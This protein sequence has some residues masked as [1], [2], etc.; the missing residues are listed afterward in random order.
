MIGIDNPDPLIC[1]EL[2]VVMLSRS[3]AS[4]DE[5]S[6][7]LILDLKPPRHAE[8]D[9]KDFAPI[10]M[11]KNILRPPGEPQDPAPG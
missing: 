6:Q 1:Q 4:M 5:M 11:H 8:M 3:G 2:D 7:A 10:E 9:E